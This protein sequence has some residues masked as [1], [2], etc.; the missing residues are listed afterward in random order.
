M[1]NETPI[2]IEAANKVLE[3][4]AELFGVLATP[5][6]LRIIGEL[7]SS[8]KNVS[9]LLGA[10][11]V[12]QPNMSRH[13]S[14]LYQAG[15][16]TKRRSGANVIYALANEPVVSICKVVCTQMVSDVAAGRR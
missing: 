12:S 3:R 2:T 8:E 16:V 14:V 9:H 5:V 15:I 1:K 4:A 10:I 6:R 7:C 11:D 13:L